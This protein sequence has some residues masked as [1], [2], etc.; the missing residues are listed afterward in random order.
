MLHVSRIENSRSV[1]FFHTLDFLFSNVLF[2]LV[3]DF[4]WTDTSDSKFELTNLAKLKVQRIFKIPD[5]ISQVDLS[6]E[7]ETNDG[8]FS[9]KLKKNH[10]FLCRLF[11]FLNDYKE[12]STK[13][14]SL[15][16]VF[17]IRADYL[18]ED[19]RASII[20]LTGFTHTAHWRIVQPFPASIIYQLKHS[21]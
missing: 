3:G 21:G 15:S 17:I 16:Q 5:L 13:S 19:L 8:K 6:R 14:L 9:G 7:D 12:H 20:L 1:K 11:N 4:V 18:P 10:S 2:V